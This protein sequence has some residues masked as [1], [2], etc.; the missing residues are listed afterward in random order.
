MQL[1]FGDAEG[2]GQRK[3]TRRE[4]F[5]DEMEQVVPWKALLALIE[6]HYPVTGC[7]GRQPYP[8]TTMFGFYPDITVA[9]I[10]STTCTGQPG[11]SPNGGFGSQQG[12]HACN[13]NNVGQVVAFK[14]YRQLYNPSRVAYQALSVTC[15]GPM[16]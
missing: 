12:L 4:V 1:T 13:E 16:P 3:R 9:S 11:C 10:P 8:L 6:P 15:S 5:L 2:P 7:R 14:W